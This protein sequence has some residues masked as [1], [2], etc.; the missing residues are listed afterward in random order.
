MENIS[1][2][3]FYYDNNVKLPKLT[4]GKKDQV[5][6][7]VVILNEAEISTPP[8]FLA[9]YFEFNKV[10]ASEVKTSKFAL[11]YASSDNE[12]FARA[13]IYYENATESD[14]TFRAKFSNLGSKINS[15]LLEHKI[16]EANIYF[17]NGTSE[18][19]IGFFLNGF[20]Q[21]N[22]KFERKNDQ[23]ANKKF[24]PIT[25]INISNPEKEISEYALFLYKSSFY[26]ILARELQ[27]ERANVATT[28]FLLERA[29]EIA[30]SNKKITFESIVGEELAK[31]G[32]NL[33]YSVGKG[34]NTPPALV[35][36]KYNGNPDQN[37]DVI[38]IVGKGICFDS[39]GLNIK[40]TGSME[41]MYADKSGA[42]IVLS[43]IKAISDLNLPINVVGTLA[44]AENSIGPNSYRPS[45][46]IKSYK[47]L[48]VE[49]GNTDAEGRLVLVDAM[50]WTQQNH[51]PKIL[52][53]LSTLT[54]ACMIA[55]GAETGGLF[56]NNEKLAKNILTLGE[57]FSEP[58][59][60]LPITEEHREDVKSKFADLNN[61]GSSK[62][63]GASRAAAF[64]EIFVEE[65]VKWAHLDIAGPTLGLGDKG[66]Y[67]GGASGFGVKLV[68]NYLREK[69]LSESKILQIE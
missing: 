40:P 16:K 33:I 21:T 23:D 61:I 69:S 39:G 19:S 45:D 57:M 43:V 26:S 7:L 46:I 41:T 5:E 30:N 32:L 17:S 15:K 11:V 10:L 38:A 54:G 36:L 3:T 51:K 50:T 22:H 14:K 47:G 44:L 59:W 37:A 68:L 49:I 4:F 13:F 64:L 9:R 24:A 55:L 62:Y 35:T 2:S 53:E 65:G 28:L 12:S 20:C 58:F 52:I 8:Q 34:S 42:C 6:N 56:S 27:N 48:T 31:K 18:D 66:V 63:G 60:Q 25:A 67:R 1:E 29:R